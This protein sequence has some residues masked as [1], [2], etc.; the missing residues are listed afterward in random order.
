MI[1][2]INQPQACMHVEYVPAKHRHI[3]LLLYYTYNA[4][5]F[6]KYNYN[7]YTPARIVSR[8]NLLLLRELSLMKY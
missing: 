4:Q 2:Y 7:H 8:N 3:L 6:Q 1:Y 5:K